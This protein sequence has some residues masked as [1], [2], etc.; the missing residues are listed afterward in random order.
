MNHGVGRIN[1]YGGTFDFDPANTAW[2][3][4][5]AYIKDAEGY[6]SVSNGDGTWTVTAK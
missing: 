5:A 6:T 4:D 3:D 1:I 2:G